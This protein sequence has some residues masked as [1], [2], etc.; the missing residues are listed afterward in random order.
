MLYDIEV[1]IIGPGSVKTPIWEK[2][3]E[4][5]IDPWRETDYGPILSALYDD[6]PARGERGLEVHVTSEAIRDALE[7]PRPKVR[8]ALSK[9]PMTGW[10]LP[11][12]LPS[13]IFDRLAARR[14]G[15][16]K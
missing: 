10:Y 8:Y 15:I 13:R 6:L 12:Y 16:K 5:D 14:M 9:R 11:R 1:A 7:S 2:T 3:R 4:I